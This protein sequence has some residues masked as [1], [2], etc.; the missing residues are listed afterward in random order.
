MLIVNSTAHVER[1]RERERE[2]SKLNQSLNHTNSTSFN[3][4]FSYCL[5]LFA[6]AFVFVLL[7]FPDIAAAAPAGLSKTTGKLQEITDWLKIVGGILIVGA[8]IVAGIQAGY[9]KGN[10]MDQLKGPV[11]GAIV[12]GIAVEVAGWLVG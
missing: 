1:E 5:K 7:A 3:P 10:F 8:F 11:L 6:V 2:N 12:I 9:T 4:T